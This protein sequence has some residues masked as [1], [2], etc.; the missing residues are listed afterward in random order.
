M[1]SLIGT[2]LQKVA[3]PVLFANRMECLLGEKQRI[4]FQI[5]RD[6]T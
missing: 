1:L 6:L 2:K 4:S 5:S 3:G